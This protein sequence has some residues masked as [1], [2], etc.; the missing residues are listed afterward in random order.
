MQISEGMSHFRASW[1]DDSVVM[2]E[3]VAIELLSEELLTI[4]ALGSSVASWPNP[5]LT[6]SFATPSKKIS[7]PRDGFSP[8]AR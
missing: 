2:R 4:L 8:A 5:A 7:P 1:I 3:R 6:P